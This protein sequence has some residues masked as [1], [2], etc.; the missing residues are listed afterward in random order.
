MVVFGGKQIVKPGAY[1]IVDAEGMFPVSVGGQKILAI[2]GKADRGQ[3]KTVLW[4][5]NPVSAKNIFKSGELLKAAQIAWSP[6]TS[7]PGADLIAMIRVN[8]ATKASHQLSDAQSKPAIELES[9]DWGV[10]PLKVTVSISEST[11]RVVT[12]TDGETTEVTPPFNEN[13]DIVSWIN[14]NSLL[15]N[16]SLITGDNPDL[17]ASVVETDFTIAGTNPD[18]N[19]EDWEYCVD[20]LRTEEVNGIIPVT[21]DATIH[22]YVKSHCNE[23]SDILVKKERR[24]FVGHALN[25]NIADIK[26]KAFN[27]GSHR[28]LLAS[29]GIKRAFSGVVETLSSVYTAA[30]LAGMWAGVD[31]AYPLTFDY[32]DALG[33]EK[34]Y[35]DA[36]IKDLAQNGVTVIELVPRRGYRVVRAIT[37]H[38]SS[39]N[40]LYQELS[41]STLADV[42]SQNI[43]DHL[44][45][46]FI[47]KPK[48]PDTIPSM[49]TALES[50]LNQFV[51]LNWLVGDEN[52]PPYRNI[53]IFQEGTAFFVNWEGSISVPVNY[54][55]ITSSFTL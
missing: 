12:I 43:R 18:P 51:R 17:I 35:E 5:N 15:V 26:T 3:P 36:E 41:V 7:L 11:N 54:V 21:S 4:F 28:A 25:E 9:K 16:A 31:S 47:G 19:A 44:E 2:I 42:M 39:E 48:R 20:L 52:N 37:T 34:I 46:L 13:S 49:Q 45:M 27:L 8:P 53:S 38:I 32:V 10:I 33:L 29:P 30:A 6:S 22:A 40:I 14:E 23:M 50:M 1:S 55:L 24:M